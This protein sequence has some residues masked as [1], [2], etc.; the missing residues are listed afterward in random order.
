[1]KRQ[2]LLGS[3]TLAAIALVA[4]CTQAP[5]A[6]KDPV[7]ISQGVQVS[8]APDASIT[9]IMSDAVLVGQDGQ[10]SSEHKKMNA[11]LVK[12]LPI[13]IST[14]YRTDDGSTGTNLQ[15][16]SG[17]T[18]KVEIRL[19]VQNL[20]V[21]SQD[22]SYDVAGKSKTDPALVGAPLTVMASAE[23]PGIRVDQLA[24]TDDKNESGTNGVIST[25]TRTTSPANSSKDGQSPATVVQW[26]TLLAPPVSPAQTT[27]RLS[28]DV[29]NFEV[30]NFDIAVQPGM[31]TDPSAAGALTAGV[32]SN[33]STELE[34][35]ERTISLVMSVNDVLAR[36]GKTMTDV[37]DNLDTASGTLGVDA[38][39]SLKTNS[40]SLTKTMEG[41]HDQ[42]EQLSDDLT[43]NTEA[44][45][46]ATNEQLIQVVSAMDSMLGDTS[47]PSRAMQSS[48]ETCGANVHSSDAGYSVY[49]SLTQISSQLDGYAQATSACRDS[50]SQTLANSIGPAEPTEQNCTEPSMTCAFRDSSIKITEELIGLVVN[51]DKLIA[52]LQPELIGNTTGLHKDLTKSLEESAKDLD[53]LR[54]QEDEKIKPEDLETLKDSVDLSQAQ[55]ST[56]TESLDKLHALAE[57]NIERIGAVEKTNSMQGQNKELIDQIC[58]LAQKPDHEGGLSAQEAKKL[59]DHLTQDADC[60]KDL[61]VVPSATVTPSESEVPEYS[62]QPTPSEDVVP[63]PLTPTQVPLEQDSSTPSQTPTATPSPSATSTPSTSPSASPTPSDKQLDVAEPAA[64]VHSKPA[65]SEDTSESALPTANIPEEQPSPTKAT[66]S[67]DGPLPTGNIPEDPSPTS[68]PEPSESAL[69]TGKVPEDDQDPA[70]KVPMDVQLSRQSED[71]ST[72]LEATDTSSKND[73]AGK[74]LKDLSQQ[75]DELSKQLDELNN[76]D[77]SGSPAHS[78]AVEKLEKEFTTT[79]EANTKLGESLSELDLQQKA[80]EDRI[81]EA[82]S[83]AAL[84]S[85]ASAAQLINDQ[86]RVISDQGN[87]SRE[88]VIKA[89]DQSVAGLLATS[90]DV[91][92]GVK[93]NVEQQRAEL[94]RQAEALGT[95]MDEQ[96]ASALEAIAQSSGQSARDMEGA[97]AQ[98]S[99]SLNKVILDLGNRKV[100]GSGLLGSLS[101]SAALS[102]TADYQLALASKT[103]EEYANLREEDVSAILHRQAQVKASMQATSELPAFGIDVPQGAESTTLY[104]FHV[105]GTS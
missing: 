9:Q 37:R 39:K 60:L 30:P 19:N 23:L 77:A 70:D 7:N 38:A 86:V 8:L 45:N 82:F 27:L 65:P 49:S 26:A 67:P 47:A 76:A 91:E 34:M 99:A 57:K 58:A 84:D 102:E 5:P 18:G 42:V 71:W 24:P 44:T 17:Y 61:P 92:N 103:A 14:T 3:A 81:R 15:D 2:L 35:Q 88:A 43:A 64:W 69:P 33:S 74:N 90:D 89:F 96:T 22:V 1:M 32:K 16:L 41:V 54:K 95:G 20:T 25:S 85:S 51:G 21:K 87:L 94:Q 105:E 36:A 40:E 6:V 29:E 11:A 52:D 104:S 72:V 56:M 55:L 13:R 50:L 31:N 48:G 12:D 97:K 53:A 75:L 59:L 28:A 68:S 80:L 4:G 62:P 79:L 83:K 100:N 78:P 101:T 98:L 66:Q 93:K 73:G 46:K 63:S 10:M